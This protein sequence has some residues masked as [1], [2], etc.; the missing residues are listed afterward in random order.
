MVA[1]LKDDYDVGRGHAMAVFGLK[2]GGTISDKHVGSAG[3]HSDAS[4][5]PA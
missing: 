1:W 4:T 5:E 2:N 3:P